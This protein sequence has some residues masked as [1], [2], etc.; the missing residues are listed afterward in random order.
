MIMMMV[1]RNAY[2]RVN[3]KTINVWNN[4]CIVLQFQV[5]Q[6]H[7]RI[8]SY[9]QNEHC[10]AREWCDVFQISPCYSTKLKS[11]TD[12]HGVHIR[13]RENNFL[14]IKKKICKLKVL[15]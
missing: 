3:Q 8:T 1:I 7:C 4:T 11:Q 14:W 6:P 15:Q 10:A 5:Y 13:L 2:L 12:I 9:L